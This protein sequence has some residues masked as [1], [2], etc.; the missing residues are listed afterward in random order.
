[1]ADRAQFRRIGLLLPSSNTT[2]EIEYWRVMPPDV[3]LHVARLPLRNVEADSTVRIVEDIE[4]EARKLADADVDAIV[5][6][7]T[8]PSSRRGPGYDKELAGRIA[9]ASGKPATTAATAQNEAMAALG[10]DRITIAAPWS[11]EVNRIAAAFIEASGYRVLHHQALGLV[12]NLEIGLL[13]ERTAL[14]LGQQVD[15]PD[16]QAVMLACGN[17][18]TLGVVDALERA[19][20]KPVLTTNQVSLWAVLRLTG[21]RQPIQGWGRLLRD[22]MAA[23]QPE[24]RL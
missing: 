14:E 24:P 22:H 3:S 23:P 20:G 7:A 5:L 1:M 10:I 15:R 17:W 13:D 16:A 11:D 18:M 21:Y 12:R 9:A 4:T 8:A 19:I 2:Q 6:A